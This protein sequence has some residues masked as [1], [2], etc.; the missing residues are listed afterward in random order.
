M[1]VQCAVSDVARANNRKQHRGTDLFRLAITPLISE[2]ALHVIRNH[3][4][5]QKTIPALNTRNWAQYGYCFCVIIWWKTCGALCLVWVSGCR[6]FYL[7]CC[8]FARQ[9]YNE[10]IW[11]RVLKF[12]VYDVTGFTRLV[13]IY[14]YIFPFLLQP[15]LCLASCFRPLLFVPPAALLLF[16]DVSLSV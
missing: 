1:G 15:F 16:S 3:E 14:I 4:A 5:H 9:W 12:I 11:R 6:M 2:S 13:Y 10:K 7:R 8:Y